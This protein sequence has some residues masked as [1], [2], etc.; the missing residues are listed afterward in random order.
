MV[1]DIKTL[2]K[3][4]KHLSYGG[5]ITTEERLKVQSICRRYKIVFNFL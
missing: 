3:I 1:S 4:I 5:V 2:L